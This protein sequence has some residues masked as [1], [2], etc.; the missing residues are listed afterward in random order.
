MVAYSRAFV[1]VLYLFPSSFGF[2]LG[3]YCFVSARFASCFLTFQLLPANLVILRCQRDF[4]LFRVFF[5]F[6]SSKG[7]LPTNATF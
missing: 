5:F 1:S 2:L 4:K 3:L 6:L 7:E